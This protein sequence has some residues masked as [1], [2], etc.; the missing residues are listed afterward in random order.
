MRNWDSLIALEAGMV[1]EKTRRD[2]T[3][4]LQE[5]EAISESIGKCIDSILNMVTR[6]ENLDKG[7]V[8]VVRVNE[9]QREWE[10]TF[11][12]VNMG[13][14]PIV[15]LIC[16]G[17]YLQAI[18]LVRQELE[19]IAQF[20]HI[21]SNSRTTKKA[22][23]INHMDEQLRLLYNDLSEGAHIAS[24]AAASIQSPVPI[25]TEPIIA[26]LPYGSS[27]IP[28]YSRE[29]ASSVIKIHNQ[30]RQELLVHLK[31]HVNEILSL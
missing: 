5:N 9:A 4:L 10:A 15:R 13:A 7:I 11:S 2:L 1:G 25:G 21:L 28:I 18:C 20:K 14:N 30:L 26:L 24:H 19:G 16:E 23:N 29:F 17:Y 8:E 27:L 22:P 12:V 31:E 3:A 6:S